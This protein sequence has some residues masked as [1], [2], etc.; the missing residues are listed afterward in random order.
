MQ[1]NE[2]EMMRSDLLKIQKGS[3]FLY[4][5]EERLALAMYKT[6]SEMAFLVFRFEAGIRDLLENPSPAIKHSIDELNHLKTNDDKN[7]ILEI[8]SIELSTY[9]KVFPVLAKSVL[10]KLVPLYSYRYFDNL[11]QF[12]DKGNRLIRQIKKNKHIDKKEQLIE[13]IKGEKSDWLDS[14]IE[15]RDEYIHYSELRE[16][17]N[18]WI[19]SEWIG[20]KQFVSL[21][22]FNKPTVE[23]AGKEMEALDYMLKIKN[24]LVEFLNKFLTLCE[25][26]PER[27]PKWYLKCECGCVFAEKLANLPRKKKIK[28]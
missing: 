15:L 6:F 5:K 20:K 18:F 4:D 8:D 14:L 10:D 2:E 28:F 16:Y 22:D 19:P 7:C 12:D 27:R 26:T 13:L 21:S 9:F 11:R 1:G 23:I 3:T 24:N 25:F 17:K